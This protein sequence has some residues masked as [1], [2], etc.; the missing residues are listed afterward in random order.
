MDRAAVKHEMMAPTQKAL[1]MSG[2]VIEVSRD[3]SRS[4]TK[5]S[6]QLVWR[7]QTI[8]KRA[9]VEARLSISI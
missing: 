1:S 7:V 4:E 2:F 6:Q 9:P 3:E 5:L 8:K